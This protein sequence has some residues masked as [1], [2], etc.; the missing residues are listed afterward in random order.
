MEGL[1]T[2]FGGFLGSSDQSESRHNFSKIW[3]RYTLH[4]ILKFLRQFKKKENLSIHVEIV[5]CLLKECDDEWLIGSFQ[6]KDG[7]DLHKKIHEVISSVFVPTFQNK[8]HYA[9]D[10]NDFPCVA[11]YA[12]K[13]ISFVIVLLHRLRALRNKDTHAFKLICDICP[14]ATIIALD[15]VEE[16]L[17]TTSSSNKSAESLLCC[18]CELFNVEENAKLL[19]CHLVP[20]DEIERV[21]S[22]LLYKI[23]QLLRLKLQRE[24]WKKNPGAK[25]VFVWCLTHTLFPTLSESLESVLP[26]ALLFTD[27]YML[28]NKVSGVSCLMHIINNVSAEE[29][30]WY[31]RGEVILAA[32]RHQLYTTEPPLLAKTIPAILSILKVV[33]KN[34]QAGENGRPVTRYDEIYQQLLQNAEG[35]NILTLRRIYTRHLHSFVEIMGISAIRYLSNTLKVIG[36]FLEISDGPCEEARLSMVDLLKKIIRCCW[37]RIPR[38]SNSILKMLVKCL[39]DLSMD[40]NL[41]ISDGVKAELVAAIKE[42]LVLLKCLDSE[43]IINQLGPLDCDGIPDLCRSICKQVVETD[44]TTLMQ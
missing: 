26:P 35:E 21:E 11:S 40:E 41:T 14:T 3:S 13:T 28:E 2:L 27:D 4:D 19:Q 30:R 17:W 43:K 15:H 5:T 39:C 25:S 34:P 1:N 36:N 42:T 6:Q 44:I 9:F 16:R 8:E 37:P 32:L 23:L 38:Y 7:T 31:G 10:V 18:L 20:N 24:T 29:L 33:E 22:T 12:E